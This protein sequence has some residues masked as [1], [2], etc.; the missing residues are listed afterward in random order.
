MMPVVCENVSFAFVQTA[1]M[2]NTVII[3]TVWTPTGLVCLNWDGQSIL[4]IQ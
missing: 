1:Q 2:P 3:E 4:P